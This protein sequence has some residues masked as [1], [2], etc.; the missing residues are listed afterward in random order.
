MR[1]SSSSESHGKVDTSHAKNDASRVTVDSDSASKDHDHHDHHHHD[2]DHH[3]H[4]LITDT[5]INERQSQHARLHQQAGVSKVEAF[6]K[7][8]YQSGPSGR[9]LLYVLVA[10]LALT[11]FAYALDQ[12]ITYQF[13]A[14]ASSDFSQHASLG[15]VNTA[16]SIIRAISKPFLGKLS[17]ITSRP[18]TYV[19]VLVVYAVGFAVAASSQGLAAYVVGASLTAFG[20]SGLDLLSDIIVGDLTPLE[21]RAFW[22]GM[23]G[24]PFLITTFINGFISDAFIPDNWRWGLAMFAIMMP[25]LLTPAIWTL[26]GM[27]HKAAKMGMISMGD[28][29]LAR[30]DGIKVQGMQ[31]YLSISRSI[32]IEMDLIGLL[33]LGLA[34]SLILLSLNLAPAS[35]GGWSNPSMIAMLVIGFLI[36]ALF[37]LYETLLAPV[38]ITPR[39]I[40]TN[41]AFLC[42]LT[43]DVFNQ[44][45]SATRN[46]YWSSYIYII[47]PW[48]NYIWTI[49]IGTTTLT[50][51][52]MSPI[53]GLIHRATHRYKTLMVIGAII[54]LVGYAI[55]LSSS[56]PGRST[57]S[58]AQLAVSQVML[59]MG[60]WSVIGARVGS[61]A[62]VPHQ[63]LS[64]VISVMSLWSTM[65]SSIGSTIAATIWQNR[66]LGY[67]REECPPSTPEATLKKIY[68]SIKTLKTKYSWDDPIREGAIRAYTR[69][70]GIILAVSLVLAAVPVVLSC[71]MPNYYLGKQQNAVTNTNVLGEHT[72]VPRRVEE[73]PVNGKPS[74]WQR[75]KRGYYKET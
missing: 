26:Y 23:L 70:N 19:V 44:M 38:P 53:G 36:L 75:V 74:L 14:I 71:L 13:D 22:S 16:S 63:D 20:K 39:R 43:V 21:W 31:Q 29:G 48:S 42:A 2:H 65:A 5:S 25:V 40:L 57:L 33:L 32:A 18:T 55:G 37:I 68:G 41:R 50:L 12:G 52:T 64:V 1:T 59:G 61:Q 49:F 56:K 7:A 30:E 62:S 47:K 35:S 69:T 24:T 9:L 8:L 34:F 51:C 17:D 4:H 66:M 67:M 27:Q 60:A 15:A 28:S 73:E 54:K 45:A 11:M 72:E 3:D 6:N 10:S 46:N 58:T